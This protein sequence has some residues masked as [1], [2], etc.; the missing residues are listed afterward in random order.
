MQIS[1]IVIIIKKS[2]QSN[3]VC[4]DLIKFKERERRTH[5][6]SVYARIIFVSSSVY[7]MSRQMT[8]ANVC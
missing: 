3:K 8:L 7:F 4:N 6:P 1:I 5:I 2:I